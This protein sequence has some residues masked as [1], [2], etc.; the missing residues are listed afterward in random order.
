MTLKDMAYIAA[1]AE[2]QS[3]TRAA[4]KLYVAQPALSQCVHKVEKELGV[5]VFNRSSA[6]VTLTT[7]GECF[8]DFVKSTLHEQH[9]MEKRLVDMK[10][11]DKGVIHLGF[12]GTQATYV[13]PYVLP[14][15][16]ERFPA[17]DIT[18]VEATAT[19]ME[20]NLLKGEVDLGI[21]HPPLTHE[22]LDSFELSYDEMVIIPRSNSR[23]HKY[24][25]Y[26]DNSSSPYLDMEFLKDE[27]IIVTRTWQKSRMITEQI[28]QRAGIIPLIKQQARSMN[29]LDALAQV[30]Y[31]TVLLPSKQISSDLKRRGYYKIDPLYNVPYTF[32]VVTRHGTYLPAPVLKLIDFLHEIRGSF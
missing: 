30:N 12:T 21:L 24:I 17:I 10:N 22:D 8:L 4:N 6:R 14:K 19:E 7:E 11:E 29:T 31:G 18:L 5:Q 23:F 13:L 9:N 16:K 25:Y 1:V 2:E 28:F 26:H 32:D 27:P 15:F 20:E 3:I